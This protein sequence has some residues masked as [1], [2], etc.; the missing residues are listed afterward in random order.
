[1][2]R[3]GESI[4]RPQGQLDNFPVECDDLRFLCDLDAISLRHQA[5]LH[6]ASLPDREGMKG[7]EHR[8]AG[9][10]STL[11]RG[12]SKV[13]SRVCVTNI[14]CKTSYATLLRSEAYDIRLLRRC[15]SESIH[16]DLD[17]AISNQYVVDQILNIA[18][19][20]SLPPLQRPYQI[21]TRHASLPSKTSTILLLKIC[22]P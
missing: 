21:P 13:L 4:Y 15:L 6:E 12:L 5:W 10:Y 19:L 3:L 9:P 11:S 16:S 20:S 14:N 7:P 22:M 17:L 1:M 18:V 2:E 8:S